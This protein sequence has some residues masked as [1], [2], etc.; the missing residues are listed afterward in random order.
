LAWVNNANNQ[1]GFSIE[2]SLDGIAFSPAGSTASNVTAFTATSLNPAIQY[3]YRVYAFNGG[4]NSGYSNTN[5]AATLA[6]WTWW[7]MAN[8]TPTQLTNA[9]TSGMGA[10]PA[11]DGVPN[12]VK[13]ALNGS[14]FVPAHGPASAASLVSDG[15]NHYL[16]LTCTGNVEAIDVVLGVNLSA[17]LSAWMSGSNLVTGPIPVATNGTS[18]TEQFVANAPVTSAPQQFMQMT[19]A[20]NGV[21]N[22]WTSGPLLPVGLVE[23]AS[24]WMGNDLYETGMSDAYNPD[25]TSPMYVYDISS[26]TWTRLLPERPY[27]GNHHAI[28]AFNG[29]IYI[30]GGLDLGQ[31][32]VQIYDH[33]T[34]GWS[35]GAPMPYPAGAC[36]TALINGKIY[37]AGGI[38]GEVAGSQSG[39][40]TNAAAVYDP[41]SNVWS[42][43]PPEPYPLNHTASGTD[44]TNF[45][46]F[47]GR[48]DGEA[49]ANGTNIVQIYFPSSNT[50]VTSADPGS[51]IAPLPQARGAM[52]RAC[53]YNGNFYV[54]GG[55]TVSGAGATASDVYN[56]VDVYNVASNIWSLGTPMPTAK[57]SISGA[58]RGDRVYV[59]G[60]GLVVGV[61]YSTLFDIYILP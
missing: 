43:L 21:P 22:S 16:A 33:S 1:T 3:Y 45:Y 8:F 49:P 18:V 15:T 5:S 31:G 37:V 6:P 26:N 47:G 38:I 52:G 29:K 35:L 7:Q 12:L 54:M 61:S 11:G 27:E 36:S 10:D 50:W 41:V 13:Y 28:E 55:E 60:G 57:H 53:Y 51:T 56:R 32:Q 2:Q 25:T 17:D 46:L 59:P 23:M 58:L 30:I 39:Y 9:A 34:N 40:S 14:P 4:G 48:D 42:S 20:Y 24:A 44:G 19:V